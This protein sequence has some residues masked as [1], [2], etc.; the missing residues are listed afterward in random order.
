MRVNRVSPS[1]TRPHSVA[2]VATTGFCGSAARAGPSR[3][4]RQCGCSGLAPAWGC[5]STVL[6][7][8]RPPQAA[9]GPPPGGAGHR[10]GGKALRAELRLKDHVFSACR[11]QKPAGPRRRRGD[12]T[13]RRLP[14][15]GRGT[16][17]A[18]LFPLLGLL[19]V[20]QDVLPCPRAGSA[21]RSFRCRH[22]RGLVFRVPP[23]SACPR[24]G[25]PTGRRSPGLSSCLKCLDREPAPH[26]L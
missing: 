6:R 7:G 12:P 22:T 13:S 1:N 2:L 10:G 14:C 8:A 17:R 20:F 15:Q 3:K 19:I 9:P 23:A 11:A 24:A 4:G 16:G 21:V 26:L 18:A 25:V 5:G